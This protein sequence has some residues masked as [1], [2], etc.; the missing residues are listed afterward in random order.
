MITI[1]DQLLNDML[2]LI[3]DGVNMTPEQ[4]NK[5]AEKLEQMNKKNVIDNHPYEIFTSMKHGEEYFLTY[6]FDETKK[7]NR[8]Q[9]SAKTMQ[10]LENKIYEAHKQKNLLTFEK[11]SREWLKSYKGKVKPQTFSRTMTDYNRFIPDCSLAKKSIKQIEATDIE[12]YLEK[13]ILDEKLQEQAYKNLKSILNGIFKHARKRKYIT[14]NPMDT[15]EVSTTNLV[16]LP[17]KS[18]EA[19]VFTNKERD[20]IKN[21]II[22]DSANYKT[23]APYAILLSFQLG[24]RV[25]ELITLKW[26]DIEKNKI[27]IQRQEIIYDVYD[28]N[29]NK[30][31]GSVHEV[32][33]YTKTKAGERFLPLTPEAKQILDS[34]KFWN[35]LHKIKSEYIFADKNGTNFNRQR[36]NTCL[37]NY[38]VAVDIIKKSSHKIRRSVI[39]NLLD[40]IVNKVSVQE[41]AG[42]ENLQTTINAYYKD[43]SEDDDLF[44]GMCACL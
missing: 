7:D 16:V 1:T 36:I 39:S 12:K 6:V 37:Y 44:N 29:L 14:D 13:T 32:V 2:N 28:E 30:T 15:V 11:V 34:V 42:H 17:K 10:N 9:I 5:V 27:H 35:K 8:R 26:S 38:C 20:L 3:P 19:T 25:G 4:R 22:K 18:K 41:F 23:T 21:H 33:E 43:V 40:N 31:A 24:L